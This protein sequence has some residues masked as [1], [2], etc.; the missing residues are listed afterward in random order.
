MTM[1]FEFYQGTEKIFGVNKRN[2][3]AMYIVLR[4]T[5]AQHLGAFAGKFRTRCINAVHTNTEVMYATFGIALKKFGDRRIGTR[6]LHQLDLCIAQI[7]V[8]HAHALLF[9]DK[10]LA[11]FYAIDFGKAPGCGVETGNNNRYVG[12]AG[13]HS[14]R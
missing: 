3:L 8:S 10:Y 4:T 9:V 7:N 2:A 13:D 6:W 12:E 1:F 14:Y 11:D 5:V